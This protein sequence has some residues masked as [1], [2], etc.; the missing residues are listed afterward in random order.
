MIIGSAQIDIHLAEPRSLKEKR[1]IVKS[2]IERV[3]RRFRVAVAEIDYLE[4]WTRT[5]L[6][7]ACVSNKTVHAHAVLNSVLNFIEGD[8]RVEVTSVRVEIL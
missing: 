5:T 2:L 4:D 7:I 1:Q 8:G 3:H 6:G